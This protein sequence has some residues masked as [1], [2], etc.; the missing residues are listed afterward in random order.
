MENQ[1]TQGHWE[2]VYTLKKPTEVSWFQEKPTTS[3]EFLTQY[4]V[5]KSARIIDIGGGDSHFVDFLLNDGYQN[6]T[7][8]DISAA[9]LEKANARLG[10]R[11][12]EVHWVVSD[13]TAFEPAEK[14][15]FWHDRAAF[16]FLTTDEQI[17]KYL[18]IARQAV[19]PEG[20]VTV[21]TFS[22]N[23]PTK[24]SGLDIRQYSETTMSDRFSQG[25]SKIQCIIED[26]L[27][28]FKTVQNFVFCSFRRVAN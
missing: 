6:I 11:A 18:D 5:S 27:T 17:E 19:S 28:P 2:T 4:K 14:F 12:D 21:G 26:H 3:L 15:D 8:L 25:F 1:T 23:G 16:H 7:V 10:N 9:A 22:E 20:I 24:C 13:I